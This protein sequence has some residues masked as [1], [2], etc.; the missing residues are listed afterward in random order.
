MPS[1]V[2]LTYLIYTEL[3]VVV[4]RFRYIRARISLFSHFPKIYDE[5]RRASLGRVFVFFFGSRMMLPLS[6]VINWS[7]V[8]YTVD[9]LCKSVV[10]HVSQLRGCVCIISYSISADTFNKIGF[11][12]AYI[13][14]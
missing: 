6:T 9:M 4:S 5:L 3:S 11:S 14:Y 2:I 8:Y 7:K 10:S 13:F 1:Y 12:S